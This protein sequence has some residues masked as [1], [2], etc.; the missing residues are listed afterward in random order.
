MNYKEYNDYQ[1]ID[2]I[3]EQNE[4]AEQIIYEKYRPLIISKANKYFPLV[5]NKGVEIND[6]IQEGLIGLADAVRKYKDNRDAQFKTFANLCIEREIQTYVTKTNRFK[7][8]TLNNALSLSAEIKDGETTFMEFL[9]DE[10]ANPINHILDKDRIE[11]IMKKLNH[12]LSD[13]E[14]QVFELKR[15]NFSYKEIADL[16]GRNPKT[17]DNALQRIK[18][19]FRN[20]INE[21]DTDQ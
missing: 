19:K 11:L 13:I 17:I 7:H 16:L 6:L 21:I 2:M 18:I 15:A 5:K 4:F 1:L 20:V 10:T 3:A 14:K 12:A 8:Q 9:S